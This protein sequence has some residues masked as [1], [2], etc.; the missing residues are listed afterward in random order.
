MEIPCKQTVDKWV[1]IPISLESKGLS[2]IDV[3]L[4]ATIDRCKGFLFTVTDIKGC[5]C[6]LI[7]GEASLFFDTRKSHPVHFHF[8]WRSCLF[9]VED[10]LVHLNEPVLPG[11]RISG[12]F[13]N[14]LKNAYTLN[15][16][17]LCDSNQT[18]TE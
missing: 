15:L 4:P 13:R 7:L 1:I 2:R 9:R 16:Y 12:Y 6:S 14:H 3:K 18:T 10:L 11:S 8:S 5:F 17:L